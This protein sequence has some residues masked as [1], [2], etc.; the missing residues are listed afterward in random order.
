MLYFHLAKELGMTVEHLLANM[1]NSEFLEWMA[2][3]DI[4]N[5]KRE[6][7]GLAD[8]ARQGLKAQKAKRKTRRRKR[9]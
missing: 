8:K 1:S 2:Y 5:D 4:L 9:G 7:Q 3:Y 6:K